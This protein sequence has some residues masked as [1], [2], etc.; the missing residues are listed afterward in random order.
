M[1]F[2]L[3]G[4]L[5]Y[6]LLVSLSLALTQLHFFVACW[7][8][9]AAV[10][11]A[12]LVLPVATWRAIVYGGVLGIVVGIIGLA[13]YVNIVTSG[14][15]TYTDGRIEAIEAARPYVIQTGALVGGTVGFFFRRPASKHSG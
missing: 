4:L 15:R 8:L 10:I 12:N 2:S 14:P 11:V 9:V 13:F 5:F 6:A 3:R 7:I 1:Q